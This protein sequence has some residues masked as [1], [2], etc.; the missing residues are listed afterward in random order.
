MRLR[1]AELAD[2]EMLLRWRNDSLTLSA[3]HTS[4][5]VSQEGHVAWLDQVLRESSRRLF[6]AEVEGVAVGTVRADQS[7]E[8]WLLS[9]TIAPEHRGR[10]YGKAM[11]KLAADMTPGRL[12]AEIK[13]GNAASAAIADAAGLRLSGESDGVLLFRRD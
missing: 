5:P 3:S 9:W 10:G 1:R 4:A 2:G 12:L 8:G 11:V 13:A 7:G 6:I